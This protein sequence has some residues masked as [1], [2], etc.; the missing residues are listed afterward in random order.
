MSLAFQMYE[1]PRGG[2]VEVPQAAANPT[3][4]EFLHRM[5]ALRHAYFR[6][7]NPVTQTHI[8]TVPTVEYV[9]LHHFHPKVVRK[10]AEAAGGTLLQVPPTF[11]LEDTR[12]LGW[13]PTEAD[14]VYNVN[15][16]RTED[17]YFVPNYP[18][19]FAYR[20]LKQLAKAER[21]S[22]DISTDV[23]Q[24]AK[25]A[26]QARKEKERRER[27]KKQ[28]RKQ[29][30]AER[31]KREDGE[32]KASPVSKRKETLPITES[33]K[34]TPIAEETEEKPV[35]IAKEETEAA[36]KQPKEE[37]KENLGESCP[38]KEEPSV[39]T[40]LDASETTLNGS[41]SI[42]DMSRRKAS[43]TQE[44]LGAS[45]RTVA[46]RSLSASYNDLGASNT[47]VA[48]G[49]GNSST[50]LDSSAVSLQINDPVLMMMQGSANSSG[51]FLHGSD[52]TVRASGAKLLD[53]S[54][55]TI[56]MSNMGKEAKLLEGET[57]KRQRTLAS[58]LGGE[59]VSESQLSAAEEFPL[60]EMPRRPNG[61]T[62]HLPACETKAEQ[63]SRVS[64]RRS[65]GASRIET[66][67]ECSPD[68]FSRVR[69]APED[70]TTPLRLSRFSAKTE[71]KSDC[72]PLTPRRMVSERELTAELDAVTGVSKPSDDMAEDKDHSSRNQPISDLE[73]AEEEE[74]TDTMNQ[75]AL[76]KGFAVRLSLLEKRKRLLQQVTA[77]SKT[78]VRRTSSGHSAYHR[79]RMSAPDRSRSLNAAGVRRSSDTSVFLPEVA[80][81]HSEYRRIDTTFR[82]LQHFSDTQFS[83]TKDRET[84]TPGLHNPRRPFRRPRRSRSD[85]PSDQKRR[86]RRQAIVAADGEDLVKDI[87]RNGRSPRRTQSADLL[88]KPKG[89]RSSDP[90]PSRSESPRRPLRRTRSEAP[91]DRVSRRAR[92]EQ[93]KQDSQGNL[94]PARSGLGSKRALSPKRAIKRIDTSK[95]A[96]QQFILDAN[97]SGDLSTDISPREVL[98]RTCSKMGAQ[99]GLSP[100]RE[101]PNSHSR[102]NLNSDL[103]ELDHSAPAE[104]ENSRDRT[105]NS[106]G[107]VRPG[108]QKQAGGRLHSSL[109]DLDL[110]N[111]PIV[112]RTTS[113]RSGRSG[114]NPRMQS[115]SAVTDT[116]DR[117]FGSKSFSESKASS[118]LS[119]ELINEP[120]TNDEGTK[121]GA[122]KET[123]EAEPL[124]ETLQGTEERKD[125]L[126]VSLS[127][128]PALN[129]DVSAQPRQLDNS[130]AV[131]WESMGFSSSSISRPKKTDTKEEGSST[132]SLPLR[133][134]GKRV[135]QQLL[136]EVV[137]SANK[138]QSLVVDK[139]KA[140]GKVTLTAMEDILATVTEESE[141][142]EDAETRLPRRS[143][144]QEQAGSTLNESE[145]SLSLRG[146]FEDKLSDHGQSKASGARYDFES[147]GCMKSAQL[148]TVFPFK[149]L[150]NKRKS[151]GS[152]HSPHA[153]HNETS[154]EEANSPPSPARYESNTQEH[155]PDL[156]PNILEEDAE[157]VLF[158]TPDDSSDSMEDIQSF[159]GSD[160][161]AAD[162]VTVR[163]CQTSDT[164]LP[165][166]KP[167]SELSLEGDL[168]MESECTRSL[169]AASNKRVDSGSFKLAVPVFSD[170][171]WKHNR[172]APGSSVASFG[173][174]VEDPI[175]EFNLSFPPSMAM[176][177]RPLPPTFA[178]LRHDVNHSPSLPKRVRARPKA[179][180]PAATNAL[181]DS[182]ELDKKIEVSF[183]K[184][185]LVPR[186]IYVAGASEKETTEKKSSRKE[187]KKA[188]SLDWEGHVK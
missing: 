142:L 59:N 28:L 99:R 58:L 100:M 53:C 164:Q 166:L 83:D 170:T 71:K 51:N 180:P 1:D 48:P 165:A 33:T 182:D 111:P 87:R 76:R 101:R 62:S 39:R 68:S 54:D 10:L 30:Q 104:L 23:Y 89:K 40:A 38:K 74:T 144:V 17:F 141:E 2:H 110:L 128:I 27:K 45:D 187:Q 172:V 146:V 121:V 67:V 133:L 52:I 35:E 125:G 117:G 3:A 155:V 90:S 122:Q 157:P 24:N 80:S 148:R 6:H 177:S 159:S 160:V 135:R 82:S 56:Q 75:P 115:D 49:A 116:V 137:L 7:V 103:N 163:T 114:F 139:H 29:H 84:D 107:D 138:R 9:A 112:T 161:K 108:L 73:Q 36:A 102:L 12:R 167:M 162:E 63:A 46:H 19:E 173:D 61:V 11:R 184:I 109:S 140:V 60:E 81:R 21:C 72:S 22:Q 154:D 88:P 55:T 79:K 105:L 4:Y 8:A 113:K 181:L 124:S 151:S 178:C 18:I 123:S 174:E 34:C 25:L 43:T 32:T 150:Q 86:G 169:D 118:A 176:A 179:P 47:T 158:N 175:R 129:D 156:L 168:E 70:T 50:H 64:K 94:S 13:E 26:I 149:A 143:L 119:L 171:P 188:S 98:K 65:D 131:D 41:F 95:R 153:S 97:A 57:P 92:I 126:E 152:F 69:K 134:V 66:I 44:D 77:Q 96:M 91:S 132:F 5:N 42:Q 31:E 15:G 186:D 136:A 145:I 37:E 120:S 85:S 185:D 106:T 93:R 78:A 20:D 16:Q 147:S 127:E 130:E 14:R 183:K